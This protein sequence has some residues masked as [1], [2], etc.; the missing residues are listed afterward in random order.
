MHG[1][2]PPVP[3]PHTLVPTCPSPTYPGAHLF[4]Q[5]AAPPSSLQSMG[6]GGRHWMGSWLNP[7][8]GGQGS[9]GW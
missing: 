5:P 6:G 3:P 2:F 8:K 7:V 1:E 9:M 4:P